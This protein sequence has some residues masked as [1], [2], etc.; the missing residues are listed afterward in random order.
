MLSLDQMNVVESQTENSVSDRL[1]QRIDPA[2]LPAPKADH[3]LNI[4]PHSPLHYTDFSSTIHS[5][6]RLSN[7]SPSDNLIYERVIHP[8]NTDAFEHLL[9]VHNLTDTYPFLVKNLREGF[10]I[11]AMPELKSTIIIPNHS[12]V[13]ENLDVVYEYIQTE[14]DAN[15]MTG[16]FNRTEVER[17]LRGPFYVSPLIVAVQDQGPGL[18]PKRRVCRNL[19]KGDRISGMGSVNSFIDKKDFP[20]RFDMAFRVADAVSTVFCSYSIEI[21]LDIHC[22]TL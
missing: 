3:P 8:Y 7:S 14:I 22:F 16:P 15:R 1:F 21:L 17:I 4:P 19:S 18:P 12:S 9:Q 11:G 6:P 5:R 20:T 10:P 13:N 2:V